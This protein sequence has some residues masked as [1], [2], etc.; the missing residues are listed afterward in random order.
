MVIN[1][2]LVCCNNI[3][4]PTS[5]VPLENRN[6]FLPKL[7]SD[8]QNLDW[9]DG[10]LRRVNIEKI[11]DLYKEHESNLKGLDALKELLGRKSMAVPKSPYLD[12][13]LKYR[14]S[15]WWKSHR[16]LFGKSYTVEMS[17]PREWMEGMGLNGNVNLTHIRIDTRNSDKEIIKDVKKIL[18][19]R[20]KQTLTKIRIAG[21]VTGASKTYEMLVFNYNVM[22]RHLNGESPLDIFLAEKHRFRELRTSRHIADKIQLGGKTLRKVSKWGY[23]VNVEGGGRNYR[24]DGPSE[25]E[26]IVEYKGE[27][28]D[29]KSPTTKGILEK[30]LMK[31]VEELIRNVVLETQDILLGVSDGSFV[32]K[33]KL[34]YDPKTGKR[35][36]PKI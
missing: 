2:F 6:T 15:E 4:N 7:A 11:N 34:T 25:I 16:Y 18:K 22:V 26:K 29:L 24:M 5:G 3:N 9:S 14:F 1:K 12:L 36:I 23:K 35:G 13:V 19:E 28:V 32:K 17:K 31:G 27:K 30:N 33:I 10:I 21:K 20:R 8:L